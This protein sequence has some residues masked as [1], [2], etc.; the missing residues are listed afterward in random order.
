MTTFQI[1][2]GVV[3]FLALIVVGAYLDIKNHRKEK[4]ERLTHQ[5][6]SSSERPPQSR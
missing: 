1:I 2:A 4:S 6:V 5:D 3:F